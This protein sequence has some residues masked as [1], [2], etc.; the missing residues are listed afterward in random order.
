MTQVRVPEIK[1]LREAVGLTVSELAKL[2]NL[3]RQTIHKMEAGREVR[4][5]T[6]V[7]VVG[8]LKSLGAMN[9]NPTAAATLL[10][11]M[12]LKTSDPDFDGINNPELFTK[13]FGRLSFEAKLEIASSLLRQINSSPLK[14][15]E[16]ADWKQLS[17]LE[18][19]VQQFRTLQMNVAQ[20]LQSIKE[21]E[22]KEIEL[23]KFGRNDLPA[24]KK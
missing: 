2:T 17:E 10:R 5:T 6:A 23:E 14:A 11:T 13:A 16:N 12:D 20:K 9:A 3:S 4:V 22:I 19:T 8:S 1:P 21:K 15:F 7:K 18:A 24:S